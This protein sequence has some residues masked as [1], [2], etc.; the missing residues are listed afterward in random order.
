MTAPDYSLLRA[1]AER[2][3]G[4]G[5]YLSAYLLSEAAKLYPEQYPVL[6]NLLNTRTK[7]GVKTHLNKAILKHAPGFRQWNRPTHGF[8]WAVYKREVPDAE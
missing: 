5:T 7:R 4:D 8:T 6:Y 1:E 3:L 2:F